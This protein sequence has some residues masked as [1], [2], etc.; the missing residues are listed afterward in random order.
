MPTNILMP[1][2][3]P[4]MEEG[5][6][7]KWLVKEGDEVRS[8]DILAEIETDKATMEF[9]AVDEGRIGKILVPEGSEGVKVNQPIAVL[10]G[11]DESAGAAAATP[12]TVDISSAME[13]I[14]HAV[15]KEAGAKSIAKSESK[16]LAPRQRPLTP[17]LSPRGG[18]GDSKMSTLAPAERGR[19]QGEGVSKPAPSSEQ[20][21]N[22]RVFASPLAKRMAEQAGIE[23]SSVHGSGPRGRIVKSDVEAA[24][25]GAPPSVAGKPATASPTRGE[26]GT[27]AGTSP[28]PDAKL[29]FKPEDYEEIPHDS[30][31]KSI[32]KR[33]SSAKTLIPH[34]YLT[35]D[36]NIDR[37]L[38]AR[39]RL[40]ERS[41]KGEGAYKLSV[42]DFIVK[43]SGLALMRVPEVNASW[44]ETSILRH[45]H[46]DVGVAVSL[47]FGL[48]TPIV[49]RAE[50]KGLAQISNE[51]KSLAERARAKKLKPQ[52][53]EGGTFAISNLGMFGI[54]DFTAV[55]NPPHAAI[56]AVGA[57]EQRAIVR[58]G[59]MEIATVMTVTMSCDHRVIDGATGA[60]FL[61]AFKGFI[62]EPA[63]M[64]L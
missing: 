26:A 30:M 16:S 52:E 34:Y 47:D 40:N 33:L 10:L 25:T 2:L 58:D 55:I 7:A 45:K 20:K 36:C 51:V 31:R 56:L 64:L 39:A 24:K 14:K 3:S 41:P 32:A 9:E 1:A 61:Q 15:S 53:F 18:E 43:A 42:N 29:F 59:K 8:G 11:E 12:G 4:T 46:A 13:S 23:L 19:G 27:A 54:R 35:I 21:S 38:E 60:R 62:E 5:K 6:L 63:S 17:A 37:L 57:G 22:G 44:T 50:E 48:I 28:L 49:F